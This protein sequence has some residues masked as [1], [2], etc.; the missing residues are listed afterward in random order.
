MITW[1]DLGPRP[2]PVIIHGTDADGRH[3][4]T[5]DSAREEYRIRCYPRVGFWFDVEAQRI[6]LIERNDEFACALPNVAKFELSFCRVA[7][8]WGHIGF[9]AIGKIRDKR[10]WALTANRYSEEV[11]QWFESTAAVISHVTAMDL[12]QDDQGYDA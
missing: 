1:H 8:G 12:I 3:V 7:K 5:L 9:C 6:G 11:F 2:A 10:I 4:H